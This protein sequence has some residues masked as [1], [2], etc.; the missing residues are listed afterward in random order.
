[1]KSKQQLKKLKALLEKEHGRAITEDELI[2]SHWF[3]QE[4]GRALNDSSRIGYFHKKKLEDNPKGFHTEGNFT[5]LVCG[6][7]AVNENSW[8]DKDGIKCMPCQKALDERV[9]PKSVINNKDNWYSVHDLERYFNMD[10]ADLT[11]YVK[12]GLLKKRIVPSGGRK[13]HLELFLLKDNKGV[14]P[15][16]KLL[17]TKLV[18]VM[19]DG[20]EWFTRVEWYELIDDKEV[21]KLQKYKISEILKET[22]AK[23]IKSRRIYFRSTHPLFLIRE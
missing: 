1:M 17:P 4:L 14:L 12:S 16:K 7:P 9:I 6:L 13:P 21:K 2:K 18:K 5:C 15:P 11:K 19:R 20:E 8:Y 23:P 10:Y 22:L 3:A